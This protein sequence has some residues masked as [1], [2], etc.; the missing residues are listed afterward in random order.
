MPLD[1]AKPLG[2]FDNQ[3]DQ[4][5]QHAYGRF[6]KTPR[7]L[8]HYTDVVDALGIFKSTLERTEWHSNSFRSRV[9]ADLGSE[10]SKPRAR[11]YIACFSEERDL[12]SQWRAYA[13]N[14]DGIA[15][16]FD[17]GAC[18][19]I[20]GKGLHDP[21][22]MQVFYD[23]RRMKRIAN[24]IVGK[25]A[26]LLDQFLFHHRTNASKAEQLTVGAMRV[27]CAIFS[28]MFKHKTFG[29]EKEWRLLSLSRTAP[30][31]T[32]S[33]SFRASRFGLA[34]YVTIPLR[35]KGVRGR[36]GAFVLK[37]MIVGPRSNFDLTERSLNLLLARLVW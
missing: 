27:A 12:L 25:S 5:Q 9:I 34:P 31:E 23:E 4:I 36:P 11:T 30:D 2:H 20:M 14:G 18:D 10:Q 35:N 7:L 6:P 21:S 26:K 16:G 1:P 8:W 15:L 17:L 24:R 13:N 33:L 32:T 3:L 22:L 29:E 37:E 28:A 19:P